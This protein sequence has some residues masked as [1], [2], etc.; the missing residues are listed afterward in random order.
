MSLLLIGSDRSTWFFWGCWRTGLHCEIHVFSCNLCSN[1][2]HQNTTYFLYGTY[3]VMC[4]F[5]GYPGIPGDIG[6][7]GPKVSFSHCN[8]E[9]QIKSCQDG[10]IIE[11]Y[12][13][14]CICFYVF[15]IRKISN[16]VL[17]MCL[18]LS[19]NSSAFNSKFTHCTNASDFLNGSQ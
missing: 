7:P 15:Y 11:A 2:L 4:I 18:V 9:L 13:H 6:V 1:I 3:P 10:L 19:P 5:Q 17:N 12:M 14:L 16:S 8:K